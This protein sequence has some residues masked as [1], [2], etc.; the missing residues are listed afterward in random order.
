M[1]APQQVG[2]QPSSDDKAKRKKKQVRFLTSEDR[3]DRR[4]AGPLTI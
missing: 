3:E 2:V 4:V 1:A